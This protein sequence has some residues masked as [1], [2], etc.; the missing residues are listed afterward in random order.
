ML[1]GLGHGTVGGSHH[2]NATVHLGGT[3]DHVFHIVSVAWAV[4]VGVVTA[5]GFVLHVGGVDGDAALLL[6]RGAIDL[7]VGLGFG[8]T[9]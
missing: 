4:D 5:L 8:L 7:I 3:G 9:N 6:F 1:P 2:Q